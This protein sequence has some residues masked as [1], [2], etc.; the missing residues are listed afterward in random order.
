MTRD[1][2]ILARAMSHIDEDMIAAA[3][4]PRKRARRSMRTLAAAC[5]ALVI[6][7]SFPF[8]REVINLLRNSKDAAGDMMPGQENK[9]E[10]DDINKPNHPN[11]EE[12]TA[13]PL[14]WLPV[15]LGGNTIT[16][17]AVDD[18]E[19]TAT[20][21]IVKTD[22]IPLYLAIFGYDML[23]TT[24]PNY[25]D[26]GI[27]IRDNAIRLYINGSTERVDTIPTAPG[28][29]EVLA[30]FSVI[31]SWGYPVSDYASFYAYVGEE[32]ACVTKHM[33]LA[34]PTDESETDTASDETVSHETLD[35]ET[36]I[37]ETQ[38]VDGE[39]DP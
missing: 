15:E 28:T 29:Y 35:D 8:L 7:V 4:A 18:T 32:G 14:P 24:E 23:A 10:N 31:H 38:T 20:F 13:P 9:D 19:K 1:R 17:T 26:N 30:D 36:L 21:T 16:L 33:K 37:D 6:V 3:H 11:T 27:I 5:L 2:E 39:T 34:L 22:D 25:R 12:S